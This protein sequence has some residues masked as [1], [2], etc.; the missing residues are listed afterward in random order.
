MQHLRVAVGVG[1]P[2]PRRVVV[3]VLRGH[4]GDCEQQWR[5]P[6]KLGLDEILRHFGLAIDPDLAAAELGEVQV[7]PGAR[8]L[9][10]DAVVGEALALQPVT[11]AGVD[12]R[13][14]RVLL[15]DARADAGL[16][17]VPRPVLQHD[18]VDALELEEA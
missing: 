7:V 15:K 16:D 12:Q 3:D 5:A 4:V 8:V 1:E 10:V 2:D 17:V 18:R 13:L 11:D 9:Q 14:H 6:V